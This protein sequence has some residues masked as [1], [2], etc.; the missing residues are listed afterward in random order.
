M[1]CQATRPE[2]APRVI[3]RQIEAVAPGIAGDD[4]VERLLVAIVEAEPEP[5]AVGQRDFLLDRLARMDRRRALVLDH[6][7]RQQ[8][9]A[10]GGGIEQH[11]LGP[12]FDAA[13]EHSLQRFV[14]GVLVVEGEIVAEEETP[15]AAAA[16]SREEAGERGNVLAMDLDED[17]G[18]RLRPVDLAMD[19]FDE[20]ALAGAA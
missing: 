11:V 17:E 5:E 1:Y 4:L 16:Q 13:I 2:R 14:A 6:V 9:A 12:A 18:A 20:R 10:V 3:D 8:V 15:P 19:G 7:A